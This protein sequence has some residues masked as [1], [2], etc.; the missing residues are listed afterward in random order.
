MPRTK[1]HAC[2]G[3]ESRIRW[4][5]SLPPREICDAR[6][7][8]NIE[9]RTATFCR[10]SLRFHALAS[11]QPVPPS[12]SSELPCRSIGYCSCFLRCRARRRR[13]NPAQHRF[14][15][16]VEHQPAI[17]YQ[18]LASHRARPRAGE[19]QDSIGGFLGRRHPPQG[20][21]PGNDLEYRFGC[22][23][24]CIGGAE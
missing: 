5:E 3:W 22:R 17:N 23:R 18:I 15:G 2:D 4:R 16:S 1:R 7:S 24:T 9:K 20:R 10:P 13:R 19:E 6:S 21:R 8:F 11:S 12:R 14:G